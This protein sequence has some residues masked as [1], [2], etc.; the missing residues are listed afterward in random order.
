MCTCGCLGVSMLLLMGHHEDSVVRVM[1][2]GTVLQGV[3]VGGIDI[4]GMTEEQAR[5]ATESITDELLGEVDV[6]VDINGEIFSLTAEDIGAYTDYEEVITQAIAYGH[7]GTFDERKTAADTAKSEGVDFPVDAK[8][9]DATVDS[10]VQVL[11]AQFDAA[12]V[13]ADFV[14]MP[15]GYYMIDGV[16]YNPE[17]Y[18]ALKDAAEEAGEEFTEAELVRI[19]D[20]DMPNELR[21]QFYK[22]THYVDDY[23]PPDANIA[24]FY[25]VEATTG[26]VID[27]D[28]VVG[29]IMNAV[30]TD[31]YTTIVAPVDVTEPQTTLDDI[32]HK[33]QLI[34]SWTSSYASHFGTNRNKNVWKMSGIV[35]GVIIEPGVEWSINDTAGARTYANGW[36]PAAGISGGAFVTEAGGGVCQ[37]SSTTYNAA[38]RSGLDITDFSHHSIV[39]GYIPIG[40]DAT[41][42]TGSPDLK[43]T[44][45]YDTPV[46]IVSYYNEA[47][48]N[49][50]VEIYGVPVVHEEYG[51][52]ILN[53][54]SKQTGSGGT[55]GT[56]TVYGDT[57]PDGT[58]VPEGGS[59]T[60]VQ[61]RGAKYADVWIHYYDLEG[62]ELCDKQLFEKASYRARTGIVYVNTPDP[63]DPT[64]DP[65]V[66]DPPTTDPPTTDPPTTDPPTT[67]PP[68]TDPP[69]T[70]PPTTDPPTTD[71]PT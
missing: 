41:I 51:D 1:D 37:M 69:T 6:S 62:N 44:N 20:E 24:R 49:V 14:F 54:T 13:E 71:P 57:A 11:K 4:S 59:Y 60:Y 47:D 70:D 46:Y 34:S 38:R 12:P 64:P 32:K 5:A 8:V 56:R 21:Y 31:D 19:A 28:S 65:P 10:A 61:A 42:S 53:F 3:S 45:Q 52:V 50:T 36:F 55:P 33:T 2:Y 30:S 58:H 35:N 66:T 63:A 18:A 48:R 43:I 23:I 15:S 29:M 16:A 25:Y 7:M 67:D 17:D 9:D 27:T 68:T 39:S 22:D 26:L 40:L